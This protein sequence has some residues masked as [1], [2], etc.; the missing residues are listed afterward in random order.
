LKPLEPV[1]KPLEPVAKGDISI[2]S[3]CDRLKESKGI[4]NKQLALELINEGLNKKLPLSKVCQNDTVLANQLQK[5]ETGLL[6]SLGLFDLLGRIKLE[7][8]VQQ[9]TKMRDRI[10]Q[11]K[12]GAIIFKP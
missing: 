11:E 4:V 12:D 10:L 6:Q 8:P 7:D 3:V 1:T 5:M 9:L 2:Q